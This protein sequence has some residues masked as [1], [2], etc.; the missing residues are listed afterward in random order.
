MLFRETVAV[1]RDG[2]GSISRYF[3]FFHSFCFLMYYLLPYVLMLLILYPVL[4]MY[5]CL[6][7]VHS[8]C[9]T[10]TGH[11]PNCKLVIYIYKTHDCTMG[12]S[13]EN[14]FKSDSRWH[15]V[16]IAYAEANSG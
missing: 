13:A 16:T 12:Q 8:S 4:L 1:Y 5:Y 6:H 3:Q 7:I 14:S 11:R 15:N 9:N 10:A 2:P